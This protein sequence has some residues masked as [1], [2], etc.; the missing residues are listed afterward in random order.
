MAPRPSDTHRP[1]I[2]DVAELAGVSRQTVSRVLSDHP[3][4]A[5]TTRARIEEVI[6]DLG[7]RPNRMARALVT[8]TSLTFGVASVDMRNL[9]FA[10]TCSGLQ[11]AAREGGYHLVV[12][13][14]DPDDDRGIG[15]LETLLTLGV[16]GIVLFPSMVSG[17]DL[18]SFV[19]SNG[20]CLVMIGRGAKI[21]GVVS[22]ALDEL[23]A[24]QAIL[25]HLTEKGKRRVGL[26]MN[27][28]FPRFIH[29]R[30]EALHRTIE[31]TTGQSKVPVEAARPTIDN[32]RQAAMRL[33]AAD[34]DIDAI[35]AFN[36]T[37]AMGAMRGCH[38]LGL[39]VPEDIAIVGYDGIPYGEVTLPPLT[40]M[41]QDSFGMAGAAFKAMLTCIKEGSPLEGEV[42]LWPPQLLIRGTT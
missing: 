41:V 35:V 4:V 31:E 12:T 5:P 24:A 13:E 14:L 27:E 3:R 9:H 11:A 42:H 33:L 18:E 21:P 32:G 36:D 16:D 17:T 26:L 38:D 22:I 20:C 7:F 34:P 40:T 30:Y 10:E 37:M 15:T 8:K 25:N 1:T 19:N 28:M 39:R 23:A 2:I 6:E 29:T